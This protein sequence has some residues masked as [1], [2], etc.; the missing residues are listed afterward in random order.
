MTRSVFDPPFEKLP[1]SLPIFPLAGALLL[2][3]GRLPLNIF[4]PR[5]LAMTEDALATDRMIGMIQPQD[6]GK[7][8][9][10]P[11]VYP[12][13]CAGRIVSFAETEDSR[14]ILT[15]AGLCRFEVKAEL[16]EQRGY[17]R[18]TPGW[19]RFREDMQGIENGIM[20]RP[21]LL[22]SLQAYFTQVSIQAN[23]DAIKE[24]P[25]ERLVTSLAMICPF[26]PSEKQALLEAPTLPERA[27][28]M[29][30][31][32]EIAIAGEQG[33]GDTMSCH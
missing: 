14:Y 17:R 28:L 2:P 12:V 23:W 27:Q 8:A 13:G 31:I 33:D 21:R 16:P 29:A 20:D 5:Y 22:R 26:Q 30:T 10:P 19:E 9:S 11:P 32:I 7:N 25:D 1:Q 4:E 3:G 24:T 18:I 6:S 15:L